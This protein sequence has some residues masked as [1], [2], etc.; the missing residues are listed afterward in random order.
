MGFPTV[1]ISAWAARYSAVSNINF[2]VDSVLPVTCNVVVALNA[3]VYGDIANA[4]FL[5]EQISGAPVIWLEQQNQV[6]V[7]FEQ[8]ATRDDK[9]FRFWVN[10]GRSGQKYKDVLVTAVPTDSF[11][12]NIQRSNSASSVSAFGIPSFVNYN[13]I[14]PVVR[15]AG[16]QVTNDILRSV[17][18]TRPTGMLV[19]SSARPLIS[20][21]E[22]TS[23]GYII[24]NQEIQSTG[25]TDITG[26]MNSLE[27]DK[28]Y[29]LRVSNNGVSQDSSPFSV[30][31][32]I[33]E[34][35]PDLALTDEDSVTVSL[36]LPFSKSYI[37][38]VI[39]RKLLSIDPDQ[40]SDSYLSNLARPV[41]SSYI[42]ET[43]S[44]SLNGLNIE[45]AEDSI[46][47]TFNRP[48]SSSVILENISLQY[49][50]LG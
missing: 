48:V 23:T 4:T 2:Y 33:F 28:T 39:D 25:L 35:T 42:T 1:M 5:W 30:N 12:S 27:L 43:I 24:V 36:A 47:M 3:V 17:F 20:L 29:V 14:L 34:S 21:L 7:L 18:F 41:S 38:E 10:K 16:S 8:P 40:T 49:S 31:S 19:V 46:R 13:Y 44:R 32:V 37:D 9:V 50:S 15:E 45:D 22:L 26:V 6:N 11:T